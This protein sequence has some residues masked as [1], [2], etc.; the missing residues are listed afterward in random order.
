MAK[1]PAANDA[2]ALTDDLV[3][4]SDRTLRYSTI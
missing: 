4:D 3:R 1:P 2:S